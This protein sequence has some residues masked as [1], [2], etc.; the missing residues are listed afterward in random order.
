MAN[1]RPLI[2]IGIAL[3]YALALAVVAFLPTPVDGGAAPFL[4]RLI[5]WSQA[6]GMPWLTYGMLEFAANVAVFSPFG[7]LLALALGRRYWWLAIVLCPLASVAIE[8]AQYL[9]FPARVASAR[10]V[11]ANSSG[12]LIGILLALPFVVTPVGAQ[13]RSTKNRSPSQ[14]S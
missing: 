9:L 10:D 2:L 4:E 1:R 12:A 5:T 13:N 7:F 14:R 11:I 3:A 6:R 8:I